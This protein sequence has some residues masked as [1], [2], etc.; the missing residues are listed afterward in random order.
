MKFRKKP[1]VIDAI[2]Y[3]D[4]TIAEIM[5]WIGQHQ[6]KP[7]P[8]SVSVKRLA[9][10]NDDNDLI[11][12]TLEGDMKANV[13]DFIIRGVMNEFYACKPSIFQQ[14]YEKVE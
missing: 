1:V 5:F 11:I 12:H 9:F 4:K 7:E 6:P 10:V 8:N 2:Q 3:T 14:T 13:G